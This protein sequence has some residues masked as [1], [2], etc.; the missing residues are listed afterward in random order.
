MGSSRIGSYRKRHLTIARVRMRKAWH[1]I[2][3]VAVLGLYGGQVCPYIDSLDPF[4]WVATLAILFSLM[5]FASVTFYKY[6]ADSI[7]NP[8]MPIWIFK[9]EY[10]MY[11][12][13]GF[14]ITFINMSLFAFPFGSG[15]KIL[16][17]FLGLGFF[18]AAD[19]SLES[20]RRVMEK[21]RRGES[22]QPSGKYLPLTTRFTATA[23]ATT[24]L[25][26]GVIFLVINKDLVWLAGISTENISSARQSVISELVF[27]TIIILAELLN[28]I[29]SFSSNLKMYLGNE[30]NVLISVAN[31]NMDAKV[32]VIINDEFG[33]MG[34]YTNDMIDKLRTRTQELVITR[35]VAI[36]SMTSLAE[37]RDN[38]TGLHIIRTQY[39][40]KALAENLKTHTL[41]KDYLNDETIELLY[42]SAPL[43]DIGKVGIPDSILLKP[44]KHTDEE[45]EVMKKH[46]FY[47]KEAIEKAEAMLGSN[48]FLRY[49]REIAGSHHEKW[50]GNGYP[51]KLSGEKIPFAAR[52][53]A[54]ADV[55][56]ALIS[57]R[58]YKPA[59]THE[60]ARDILLEGKGV[61]FDPVIVDAFLATESDFISIAKKYEDA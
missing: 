43:H 31:G 59:F 37:M 34:N 5:F 45:F 44:G 23:I 41:Y 33:V 4:L 54:V 39:Y 8:N 42:K 50:D 16:L 11:V 35:D 38:E 3:S 61:H 26:M 49:A 9:T 46:A 60:K 17:G 6:F 30:N 22:D 48:S 24:V 47:G 36:H 27:V 58:V 15:M 13:A 20:E 1:Y 28:L 53:M 7:K 56:D 2:F 51:E 18:T 14:A 52:L 10:G 29:G 57:K 40:V 12:I 19:L 21:A 25:S 55:Y 32:P